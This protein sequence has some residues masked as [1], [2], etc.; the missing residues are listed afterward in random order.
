MT[1][2]NSM[3][4][5]GH[6]KPMHRDNPEGWDGERSGTG[7]GMGDT[8]ISMADSCPCMAKTITIYKVIILQLK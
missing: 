5:T 4:E 6:S 8:C 2:P 1:S 3:H 7:F